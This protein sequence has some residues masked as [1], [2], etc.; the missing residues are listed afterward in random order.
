MDN[1]PVLLLKPGLLDLALPD[2]FH[3]LPKLPVTV[4]RLFTASLE[5]YDYAHHASLGLQDGILYAFWSN[6]RG[7]EDLPGQVQCWSWRDPAGHWNPPQVLARAPMNPT[8]YETTTAINGGTALGSWRLTSFYS[9]YKGRPADG[10]GGSGKWSLPVITGAQ[11]YDPAPKVWFHHGALLEDFLLNEGPRRTARGR[12]L[13]TGEDHEGRTRIALSDSLDPV[14]RS[15]RVV[16][17]PQGAGPRFKNEPSWFQRPDGSLALFLRDDGGSRRLWL[18]ESHNEGLTWSVPR[19]TNFPDATAKCHVGQL[20]DGTYFILSNPNP[21]GLR[22]PLTIALS[23]D[24]YVFDRM[25][26]LRNEPTAP[27]LPGRFKGPGYQ[28]PHALGYGG[29]LHVIHSVNKEEIEVT[30]VSLEVLSQLR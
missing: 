29:A 1:E 2:P 19:P 15:W 24:G 10:A 27:R 22:I 26:I 28:Y 5:T 17:V 6:G 8:R 11:T 18:A 3:S 13:M 30:S 9:E 25:A 21:S 7:G 16:G 23:S 14:D 12:W 20:P 4:A